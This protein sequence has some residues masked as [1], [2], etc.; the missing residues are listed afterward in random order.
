MVGL[1]D[2]GP[3]DSR[4]ASSRCNAHFLH[5]AA[6]CAPRHVPSAPIKSYVMAML[7][8][9]RFSAVVVS[10]AGVLAVLGNESGGQLPGAATVRVRGSVL[11]S[12]TGAPLAGGRVEFAR[13]EPP[14]GHTLV[15][16]TDEAGRFEIG[17]APG[18]WLAA[19]EH[20]HL[21]SLGVTL[22]LRVA[23]VP[24]G[25]TTFR[26]SLAT[27]SRRTLARALCGSQARDSDAVFVGLV[28]GA[29]TATGLDS[30]AVYVQW[31]ELVFRKGGVARSVATRDARTDGNGWYALCG[32][33]RRAEI[34]T[35]A[36][37]GSAA[38]GLIAVESP[39]DFGRLDLS[40]DRT[41]TTPAG[42][43]GSR[44]GAAQHEQI[45]PAVRSGAHRLRAVVRDEAG[46]PVPNVRARISGHAFALGD[47]R[48]AVTL[49]ALPG[50]S[51]TLE[52]FAL[53]FVPRK[54]L[55]DVGADDARQDTI[56]MSSVKSLLDTVR[57]TTGRVF[58]ADLNGFE[59]R[60]RTGIGHY[61]TAD[62]IDRAHPVQ[63][64]NLMQG[65]PGVMVTTDWTGNQLIQM[66]A[67]FGQCTPTIWVDGNVEVYPNGPSAGQL[68][69]GTQYRA[70][71]VA[72]GLDGLNARVQP[73]EVVGVEIY[74]RQVEIPPEFI[75]GGYSQC[76]A[77]VIWTRF[78]FRLP[79]TPTPDNP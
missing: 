4:P 2:A 62:E 7:R 24:Q 57:V 36:E 12:L 14:G 67:F 61:I 44:S 66:P 34:V 3:A 15:A 65:R 50:G 40:I 77:I 45:R 27:V 54:Q 51:Q 69:A 79:K 39:D 20:P 23:E 58:N 72:T 13:A 8:F 74:E 9:R 16:Q 46:K 78:R 35:W 18:R 43:G 59:Q 71:P 49:D 32:V 42:E 22:P 37:R 56:T 75:V 52:L 76:G 19:I 64:T 41:A 70:G 31:S 38:T 28:R 26:L 63:F 30:A 48:G 53:G 21:D 5:R 17:L 1:E 55:V 6:R 60:R 47:E 25:S 73:G 29:G 68:I 10:A 11:D 33:P